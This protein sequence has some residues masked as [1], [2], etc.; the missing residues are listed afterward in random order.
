MYHL[1]DEKVA[2][3]GSV[4]RALNDM[5]QRLTNHNIGWEHNFKISVDMNGQVHAESLHPDRMSLQSGFTSKI[6]FL[7]TPKW[8][9]GTQQV[10]YICFTW[11][12]AE[13]MESWW[14]RYADLLA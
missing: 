12:V 8:V 9:R 10:V 11:E 1:L 7:P 3:S 6:V 13:L 2:I 14:K 4:H 5:V